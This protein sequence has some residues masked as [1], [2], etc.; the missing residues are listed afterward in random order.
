VPENSFVELKIYDI[1][2]RE[3]AT[4]A[5]GNYVAG[6][7]TLSFNGSSI[8]SGIYFYRI[9]S[10]SLMNNQAQFISTKKFLLVK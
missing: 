7:Y 10:R 8:S 2:G 5:N 4:L 3:V 9:I 6:F 1:L